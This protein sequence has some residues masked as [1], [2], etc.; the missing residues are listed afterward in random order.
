MI[1]N[2]ANA[3]LMVARKIFWLLK[4]DYAFLSTYDEDK[5]VWDDG[6]YVVINCNDLFVTGSDAESLSENDL[7]LYIKACKKYEDVAPAAWCAVKRNAS[8]WSVP[9]EGKWLDSY[10]EAVKGITEMIEKN[11]NTYSNIPPK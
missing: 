10:N 6:A 8:L 2:A 7:D 4:H 9:K 11:D 1:L 3:E 5:K